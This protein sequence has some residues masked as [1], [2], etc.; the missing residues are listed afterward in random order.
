[1]I[2]HRYGQPFFSPACVH[3]IRIWHG[4]FLVHCLILGFFTAKPV[5]VLFVVVFIL[6]ILTST[7]NITSTLPSILSIARIAR[8]PIV[9][10]KRTR[11]QLFSQ[12][13][14]S[15]KGA[16]VVWE[17]VARASYGIGSRWVRLVQASGDVAR[18]GRGERGKGK[19]KGG[20]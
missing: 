8:I 16:R 4:E 1:M 15:F 14:Q 2:L 11:T 7:P 17:V 13:F 6:L 19:E 3:F 20:K 10:R 9:K 5:R 12:R 18:R